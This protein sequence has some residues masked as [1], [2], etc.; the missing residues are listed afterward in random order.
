MRSGHLPARVFVFVLMAISLLNL[1]GQEITPFFPG[2]EKG[3]GRYYY[4]QA[5]YRFGDH[6]TRSPSMEQFLSRGIHSFELRFGV[7]SDGRQQWQQLHNYPQY[8]AGLYK[9]DMGGHRADSLLGSPLA[10]FFYY[11]APLVRKEWFSFFFDVS[12]GLAY[13]FRPYDY[14]TNADQDMI[15]SRLNLY[16]HLDP[17]FCFRIS[18]RWVLSLA[19]GFTHFSNGR[20]YTP[21][22]GINTF[23]LG[24]GLRYNMTTVTK[25][26]AEGQRPSLQPVYK[27]SPLEPFHP[28]FELQMMAS[29]GNV[30]AARPPGTPRG[31][32]YMTSSVSLDGVY[33]YTRLS[34]VI[35]GTD[36]FY[37]GSLQE[38]YVNWQYRDVPTAW[39]TSVGAHVGLQYDVERIT[40]LGN[41]G[42]YLYKKTSLRG[43]YYMRVG[44]RIRLSRY[45]AAHIALKTMNGPRADWIEW[46][47]AYRWPVLR[48]NKGQG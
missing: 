1:R 35:L 10:F 17:E 20:L 36:F 7:R 6:L 40:F 46:G 38:A 43:K 8:G 13:G 16:F 2:N 19:P 15:G 12:F 32:R 48:I 22:H 41:M 33:Q 25:R 42:Y 28:R 30:M 34:R 27:R 44:G 21:Q 5:F 29:L 39:K 31:P 24:M 4:M 45:L 37:D 14:E 26:T 23:D 18:D 3:E 9:G 11:G 47:L